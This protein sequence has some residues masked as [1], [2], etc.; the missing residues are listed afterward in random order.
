MKNILGHNI[1]IGFCSSLLYTC[2]YVHLFEESILTFQKTVLCTVKRPNQNQHWWSI[3][4]DILLQCNRTI[5]IIFFRV[6]YIC[7]QYIPR[8]GFFSVIQTTQDGPPIYWLRQ[9]YEV[10]NL[11]QDPSGR[12]L[13]KEVFI[14]QR[15]S[16]FR[17]D[18]HSWND[19][20]PKPS[21]QQA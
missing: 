19:F 8:K 9:F 1:V 13:I 3:L 2:I 16:L 18:A 21:Q 7:K 4:S 12:S 11:L 10:M 5:I 6:C 17:L 15:T 14:Y 20:Y